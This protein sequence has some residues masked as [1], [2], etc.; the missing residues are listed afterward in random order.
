[1][2]SGVF[3]L[4]LAKSGSEL[5]LGGTDTSQYTGS[6]EY[7]SVSGSGFWQ[8]SGANV[9]VNNKTAVSNFQTVIDSGTTIMYGPPSAVKTFYASVPGSKVY[10]STNG[11]YS[12]PCNTPPSVAFNWGG[13]SWTVSAAK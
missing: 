1:M 11:Y 8:A 7:H 13:K 9:L 12:Y 4:K 2:K 10:D 5:Y 3:G 6:I